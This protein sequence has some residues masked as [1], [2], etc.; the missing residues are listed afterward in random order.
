MEKPGP[1]IMARFKAHIDFHKEMMAQ[2]AAAMAPP[3]RQG[4]GGG[5]PQAI[6]GAMAEPGGL[7]PEMIPM[8]EP[9]VNTEEEAALAAQAGL[10]E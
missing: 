4:Q 10:G 8:A 6:A 3:Q 5:S 2:A 9:G 1:L 7:P